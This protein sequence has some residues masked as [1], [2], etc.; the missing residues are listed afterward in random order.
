VAYA[1][2]LAKIPVSKKITC[3]VRRI[4]HAKSIATGISTGFTL[5]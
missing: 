2:S 3:I 4:H 5:R 1:Q